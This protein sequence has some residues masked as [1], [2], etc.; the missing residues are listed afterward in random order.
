MNSQPLPRLNLAPKL[1]RRLSLWKLGDYLRLLYW[2]F[3]F[4]QALCGYEEEF[5]G[6]T[7]GLRHRNRRNLWVQGLL[8]TIFIPLVLSGLLQLVGFPVAWGGVIFAIVIG[9]LANVVLGAA[10]RVAEGIAFSVTVSIGLSLAGGLAFGVVRGFQGVLG[11][12]ALS[13]AVGI[14]SG[15]FVA[16]AIG[17]GVGAATDGILGAVVGVTAGVVS[18]VAV[19]VSLGI[20]FTGSASGLSL[21]VGFGLL[22]GIAFGI[23]FG[24][25]G[26]VAFGS[27]SGMAGGIVVRMVAGIPIGIGMSLLFGI[28]GAIVL[29]RTYGVS[30]GVTFGIAG[31]LASSVAVVVAILRPDNWLVGLFVPKR[32]PEGWRLPHIT[33]LPLLSLSD[34]IVQWLKREPQT[35]VANLNELLQYTLQFIPVVEAV[36]QWLKESDDEHLVWNVAQLAE[37]PYDWDLV[38]FASASPAASMTASAVESFVWFLPPLKRRLLRGLNTD[39]R[40]NSSVQATAAGFWYLYREDPKQAYAAFEK[41]RDL[42]YGSEMFVLAETLVKCHR[43]QE[44]SQN[45]TFSQIAI[46][47]LPPIPPEPPLRP[48]TWQAISGL[49]LVIEDLQLVQRV[50]SPSTKSFALN[51]AFGELQAILDRPDDLPQAERNLIIRIAE[52]WQ[53]QLLGVA[54]EVGSVSIDRLVPNPYIIGDP[55]EG[56]QFVGREDIIEQLEKHWV[57][58]QHLQSVVI[59]GHRRMGK[60]S[61]VRNAAQ[62]LGARVKLAYINLQAIGSLYQGAGD[63]LMAICDGIS[64]VVSIPPPSDDDLLRFGFRTFDRYL[65]SAIEHLGEQGLIIA[66]DEFEKIEDWIAAG[67]L[68]PDFLEVL[69]ATAQKS[70]QIAFALAGLHTLDEMTQDYFQPF[71]ASFVNIHVSFMNQKATRQLLVGD[72]DSLLGYLNDTVKSIYDLTAGQP[73][74]VQL[75]GYCLVSRYNQQVFEEGQKRDPVFAVEDVEAVIASPDFFGQGKGY[76][77][78]VWKQAAD[79]P[80]GQQQVLCALADHHDGRSRQDIVPATGLSL[81]DVNNA[82]S[83]L[84][85][86]DVVVLN[87]GKIRIIVELF[88]RWVLQQLPNTSDSSP[89]ANPNLLDERSVG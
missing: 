85:R 59:Y 17:R 26:G 78:G 64:R 20:A 67:Q 40:L 76:F 12:V 58:K 11:G 74:L 31:S 73:Y 51:R 5:A 6:G 2:V 55:V 70:S 13:I 16:V 28:A 29:G 37:N 88:R 38:R 43:T 53:V 54:G 22:V 30:E 34:S 42:L 15:V 57:L 7:N 19:G 14:A 56:K 1:Q 50:A 52:A 32:Q 3:F 87:D 69:R 45:V 86:H 68:R 21:G 36:N 71:F 60:T 41:V 46:L 49:H 82:V 62:N 24:V 77:G 47:Q 63:V 9:I 84:I 10:G 8:I 61:I 79:P 33:P 66:I 23:A 75:I 83:T 72:D 89:L 48:A 35:G 18:G 4:P 39:I 27:L 81:A 80:I 65:E 44:F 25:A